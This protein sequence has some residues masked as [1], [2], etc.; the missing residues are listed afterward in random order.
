M[1]CGYGNGNGEI[2]ADLIIYNRGME[3]ELGP[4][5][6]NREDPSNVSDSISLK[7]RL[8]WTPVL[9]GQDHW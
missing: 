2:L 5:E 8:G 3:K 4:M 9:V 7:L 6:R 1:E